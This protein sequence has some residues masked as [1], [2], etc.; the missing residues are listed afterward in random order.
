LVDAPETWQIQPGKWW[1]PKNY[2]GRYDGPISL[3]MALAKSKNSIAVKL[4][5]DVGLE[6]VRSFAQAAGLTSPLAKNL[7]LAL[8]SSEVSP[9]ELANAYCTLANDGLRA[10]PRFITSVTDPRGTPLLKDLGLGNPDDPAERTLDAGVVWVLRDTMRTVVT[11]GSGKAL[12]DF[13]R[14]VLGK[15]GT[16]NKAVDTWFVGLLPD[17]AVVAWLGFDEPRSLGRK[18][19]GGR[20]AVPVVK[21]YLE[22][23]E[24]AGPDWPPPPATVVRRL[25]DP[26]TGLLAPE[27]SPGET[28]VFLQGT[29]PSET[30][31]PKGEVDAENFFIEQYE[32]EEAKAGAAAPVAPRGPQI[33]QPAGPP[34]G[35]KDPNIAV[36]NV[37]R[38]DVPDALRPVAPVAARRARPAPPRAPRSAEAP[39]DRPEREDPPDDA[40][41]DLDRFSEDRP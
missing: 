22:Q 39:D 13:P 37:G 14:A 32:G 19:S 10:T 26:E 27:G 36:P 33:A 4:A 17:V 18:E 30:A 12:K 38:F 31:T 16:S 34:P 20:A 25:I 1:T 23:A 11:E 40:D 24:T 28:E 15:T 21:A 41:F 9:L 2:T 35:E 8:G 7:S 5:H 29:E 6:E 3:R